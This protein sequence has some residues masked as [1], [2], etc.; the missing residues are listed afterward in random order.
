MVALS[1][2]HEVA[3]AE[4]SSAYIAVCVFLAVDRLL[5][6]KMKRSGTKMYPWGTPAVMFFVVE[7]DP[8]IGIKRF[9]Q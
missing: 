3:Y 5:M 7:H 2:L 9:L 6:Y 4:V 1:G 8:F